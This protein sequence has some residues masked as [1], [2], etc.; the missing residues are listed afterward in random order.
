MHSL[1]RNFGEG[2]LY[3]FYGLKYFLGKLAVGKQLL[4][5]QGSADDE[6]QGIYLVI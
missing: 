5:V 6:V 4:E 1:Q 2:S 3:A